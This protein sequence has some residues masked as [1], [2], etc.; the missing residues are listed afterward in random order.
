MAGRPDGKIVPGQKLATAISARAW[1]RAQDAAE[2]V[3]GSNGGAAAEGMTPTVRSA[4]VVRVRN[5]SGETVPRFGVLGIGTDQGMA[6]DPEAATFGEF[7]TF[8]GSPPTELQRDRGRF[9]VAVEPIGPNAIG[10][11]IVSGCF[12]CRVEVVDETHE[13]AVPII[14]NI[15]HL[16]SAEC[17][18]L[19]L[20]YVKPGP[21]NPRICVGVM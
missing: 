12:E 9:V 3:L 13:Y 2:I 8:N 21:G 16:R 10:R 14:D 18:V 17:G 20:L 6:I 4:N 7:I 1:N 15:E 19:Q 5:L 11:A